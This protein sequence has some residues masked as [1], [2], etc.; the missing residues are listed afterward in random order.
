[1]VVRSICMVV[2]VR[3]TQRSEK[4][5]SGGEY[6][7]GPGEFK[8]TQNKE[9]ASVSIDTPGEVKYTVMETTR[10]VSKVTTMGTEATTTLM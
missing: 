10:L 4:N 6:S 7:E 8:V 1:M 5:L 3:L 2:H 9:G